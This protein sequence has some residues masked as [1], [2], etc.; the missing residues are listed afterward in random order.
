MG[1]IIGLT[2]MEATAHAPEAPAAPAS[3]TM[4]TC[5]HC[6]KEYKTEEGLQKHIKEKHPEADIETVPAD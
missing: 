5:D 1:K 6:M 2:F 4:Y 3:T